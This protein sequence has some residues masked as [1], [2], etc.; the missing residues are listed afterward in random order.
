M[1]F[2]GL[3]EAL[4]HFAKPLALQFAFGLGASERWVRRVAAA[5]GRRAAGR[6]AGFAATT[7]AT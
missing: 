1:D 5:M 7:P 2:Q 4:A 6:S 3:F